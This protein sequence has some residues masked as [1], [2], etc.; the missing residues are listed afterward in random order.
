VSVEITVRAFGG[1]ES[2]SGDRPEIRGIDHALRIWR[3]SKPGQDTPVQTYLRSRPSVGSTEIDV[4]EALRFHPELKH[5]CGEIRPAMVALVADGRDGNPIGI[6]CTFLKRDGADKAPIEPNSIM[7]GVCLG[8]AVRLAPV[9]DIIMIDGSIENCVLATELT[10]CPAWAVLSQSGL[11]ELDLPNTVTR[12]IVLVG[13]DEA[14][15]SA[16]QHASR[17]WK[18]EGREVLFAGVPGA[19]EFS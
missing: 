12:V 4:P 17:R 8:G 11:D 16:A 1:H 15:Y 2:G 5:P 3:A 13:D 19:N 7:L 14:R 10:G 18:D 6:H 9:K